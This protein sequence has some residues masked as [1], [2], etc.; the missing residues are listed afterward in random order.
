MLRRIATLLH[1]WVGLFIALFLV[2]S[3]LTGAVISWDHQIDEWLNQDL[4]TVD[5]EGPYL[6]VYELVDRVEANDPRAQVVYVPL[7]YEAG[8]SVSFLVQ[9]RVSADGQLHDLGYNEIFMDPV[10]GHVIGQRDTSNVSLSTRTLMPFLRQLHESLHV[11]AFWGSDRWGY[12]LMGI[13]ALI[14]LLDSFIGFYLTLP[15]RGSSRRQNANGSSQNGGTSTAQAAR[16]AV[17]WFQRWK[18]AWKMRFNAGAYKLNF[19]YHRAI[20]LW[21]WGLIFIIAFTSFSLNLYR[22][23]FYPAMSLVSKVTPGPFETRPS[24]PF[25]QPITPELTFQEVQVLAEQRGRQEQWE[26]PPGGIF[27]ARNMGFYSV[28]FFRPGADHASG[29]MEIANM[30]F[31]AGDGR[32]LGEYLPWKGTAAV[33]FVQLQYPLHS[34]R[35]LGL[36]GRILMSIMG[37]V[38]ALLAITGIVIWARKRRARIS[39]HWQKVEK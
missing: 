24:T 3:G 18:P 11:P 13:V 14:W 7:Q 27:Y 34:G 36:P 21:A 20:G 23:V 17:S 15:K 9:P 31:D 28:A 10:T 35:I 25:N 37:L 4:Y 1:R 8:H 2:V 5:S 29:G 16:P 32:Y 19:D 33:I 39:A 22:E 38:V 26:R 12:Q 30:Y 6:P